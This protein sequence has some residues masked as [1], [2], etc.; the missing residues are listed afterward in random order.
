MNLQ[1]LPQ[2]I[3]GGESNS[4]NRDDAELQDTSE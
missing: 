3:G 4:Q 2:G 1:R